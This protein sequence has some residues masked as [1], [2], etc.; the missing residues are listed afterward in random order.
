[1]DFKGSETEKCLLKALQGEGLAHLKY[2]FYQSML[3]NFTTEYEAELDEII[4]NEKEHG[5][6][7]FKKL[8]EGSIPV[9]IVNLEDAINGELNEHLQMYPEFSAIAEKEGFYDISKLFHDVGV[10][11]GYHADEF[12]RILS[13]I[14][15][16]DLVFK[17][18]KEDTKWKCGNCGHIVIGSNAPNEC[19]V[20][21]HPQ[22]YFRSI[23]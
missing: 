13:E 23:D 22:K 14:K 17:D 6:I 9:D 11:E 15:K 5:K 3:S 10:I 12:K 20:C 4:H 7:W 19:P 18:K 16:G 21:N 2:Q 1:M 8:H